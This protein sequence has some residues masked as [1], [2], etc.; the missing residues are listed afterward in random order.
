MKDVTLKSYIWKCVLSWLFLAVTKNCPLFP[1]G[2]HLLENVILARKVLSGAGLETKKPLKKSQANNNA[3]LSSFLLILSSLWLLQCRRCWRVP[4]EIWTLITTGYKGWYLP[5][6][7]REL[8]KNQSERAALNQLLVN[9]WFGVKGG[10][11]WP[12]PSAQVRGCSGVALS[13][14]NLY[15]LLWLKKPSHT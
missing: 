7:G 6:W 1:P 8:S 15:T 10:N 13:Y 5:E 14:V 12:L 4:E 2:K 3:W 9:G 11:A